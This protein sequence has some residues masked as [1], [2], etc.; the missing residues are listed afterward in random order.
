MHYALR[1]AEER[2]RIAREEMDWIQRQFVA[3]YSQLEECARSAEKNA[4]RAEFN[5]AAVEDR[6]N[7]ALHA[8]R[9]LRCRLTSH[10]V[11]A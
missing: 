9:V 2:E 5:A 8:L 3:E 7:K 11:H 10:P 4:D 1:L 6:M